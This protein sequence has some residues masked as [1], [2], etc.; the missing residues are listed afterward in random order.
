MEQSKYCANSQK[1]GN[2]QLIQNY[3]SASL[4]PICGKIFEKLIF[5]SCF[6]YLEY[7]NFLSPHQSGFLPGDSCVHQLLSN[8]Y[9][10]YKSFHA[11]RSFEVRGIFIDVSKTFDRV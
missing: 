6:K 2:K 5:N 11:N 9:D 10:I 8:T 7:D 3:R 4:L 1:K